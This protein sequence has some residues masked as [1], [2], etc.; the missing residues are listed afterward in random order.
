[1]GQPN[2]S[3]TSEGTSLKFCTWI[4]GKGPD[5]KQKKRKT[6]HGVWFIS[7]AMSGSHDLLLNK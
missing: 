3:E 4:D 7:R 5:I 2:I 6:G 1:L